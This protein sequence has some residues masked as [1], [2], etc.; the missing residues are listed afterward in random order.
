MNLYAPNLPGSPEPH[1]ADWLIENFLALQTNPGFAQGS[2]VAVNQTVAG[3]SGTQVKL[4]RAVPGNEP[5][6]HLV[7]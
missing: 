7:A 4:H 6:L 2:A 5:N 3:S 1:K